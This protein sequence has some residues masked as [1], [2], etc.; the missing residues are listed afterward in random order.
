MHLTCELHLEHTITAFKEQTYY[1][2]DILVRQREV[3][4]LKLDIKLLCLFLL[5][6]NTIAHIF[7]RPRRRLLL[8][9]K[10]TFEL[11]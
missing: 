6:A 11:S 5:V 9:L 2:G 8:N 3:H 7:V 4:H 10:K 1:F